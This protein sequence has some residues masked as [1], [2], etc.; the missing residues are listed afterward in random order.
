M[1][2]QKLNVYLADHSL[3]SQMKVLQSLVRWMPKLG[4]QMHKFED[5]LSRL[6][7]GLL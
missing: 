1:A 3:Q 4:K 2:F 6:P 5:S 7:T